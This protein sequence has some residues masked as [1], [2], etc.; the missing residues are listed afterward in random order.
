MTSSRSTFS[1]FV[2]TTILL[3]SLAL[4]TSAHGSTVLPQ[5]YPVQRL[6][7]AKLPSCRGWLPD[8]GCHRV[9]NVTGTVNVGCV[10][11]WRRVNLVQGSG[12]AASGPESYD[13]LAT[14]RLRSDANGHISFALRA[15]DAFSVY[16]VATGRFHFQ[17]QVDAV[18]TVSARRTGRCI[19]YTGSTEC[20]YHTLSGLMPPTQL[21]RKEVLDQAAMQTTARLHFTF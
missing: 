4:G 9:R 2:I 5:P 15:P 3:A 6:H 11:C 16:E 17:R 14:Q 1:L 8:A 21:S 18:L 7:V 12:Q 10:H 13:L 19:R 20:W